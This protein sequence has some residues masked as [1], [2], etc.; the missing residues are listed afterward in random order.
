MVA[1]TR[2]SRIVAIVAALLVPLAVVGLLTWSLGRPAERMKTVKAAVV[3]NDQPVKLNGQ[4]V[5]LGRQLTAKLAGNEI[6]SNYQW[7]VASEHSAAAGMRDGGYIATVV[8]PKNFSASAT[9]YAKDP[10]HARRAGI[11]VHTSDRGNLV[12]EAVSRQVTASAARL[13]GGELS[14]KYLDN[15]YLGFNTLHDQL[16]KAG[17]GAAQLAGGADKL[18]GGTEKLSSGAE[19]LAN[20][21]RKLADGIGRL[22]DGTGKLANGAAGLAGGLD[23]L[24]DSTAPLPGKLT[25]LSTVADMQSSG[26]R[27][28]SG[29]LGALADGLEQTAK[30]CPPTAL[31]MCH[32][33]KLQAEAARKLDGGADKLTLAGDGVA[34][35]LRAL[36]G[37]TPS[38]AGGLPALVGGIDK[39]ADGAAKLSSGAEQL[40]GGTTKTKAGASTLADGTTTMAGGAGR[41]GD[42]A[43]KLS[44][45]TGNLAGGMDEAGRKLPSY[46]GAERDKL[47]TVISDP[48]RTSAGS[49]LGLGA[50]A[51]ALYAVLAL[52]LGALATFLVVRATPRRVLESTRP[53]FLLT[54]RSARLPVLLAV[55]QSVPV[56]VV[57]GVT[58]ALSVP[59]WF[60]CTGLVA[61]TAITFTLLN[62]A[63]AAAWPVLGRFLALLVALLLLATGFTA[64]TPAVLT[65]LTNVLPVGSAV[66]GL[67]LV[68]GGSGSVGAVVTA[69]ALW[70]LVGFAVSYW[71]LERGRTARRADLLTASRI[72][73]PRL[74]VA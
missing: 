34:T 71:A 66:D 21:N 32:A 35:G 33:I 53:T 73:R 28:L 60:G 41:L 63:L 8:I 11:E 5:P 18:A 27:K 62:Q 7:E 17:D 15:I 26:V 67:R 9:S 55:A 14:A 45:G 57:L 13:L 52:W 44:D 56:T 4:L 54:L 50:G 72:G 51:T 70:T 22:D 12:D 24:R 20:G 19:Q 23:K 74:S 64:T 38:S 25:K 36:N 48:V 58:R 3:N 6:K 49:D 46:T 29:G 30:Q 10:N 65:E 40:H 1:N 69:L 16:G 42:G 68:L 31:Q 37:K 61:L 43:R 47:S 59:E 2:K 39:L